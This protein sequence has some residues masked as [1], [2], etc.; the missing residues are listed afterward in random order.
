MIAMQGDPD[1]FA[2]N[3]DAPGRSGSTAL[4]PWSGPCATPYIF[5]GFTNL[6]G[7]FLKAR[8][9]MLGPPL[10]ITYLGDGFTFVCFAFALLVLS[11]ICNNSIA[12]P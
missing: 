10:E 5:R 4:T 6:T 11:H 1:V 7:H 12:C 8:T 3:F 9:T 2:V